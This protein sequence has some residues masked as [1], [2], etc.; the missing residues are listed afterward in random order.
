M[1]EHETQHLGG[2]RTRL[3]IFVQCLRQPQQVEN[4]LAAEAG[5]I[6]ESLHA[7]ICASASLKVSTWPSFKIYAGSRRRMRG[8]PLVPVRIF[9]DMSAAWT[10][11]AGREV[12]RPSKKPAPCTPVTGPMMQF[13]RM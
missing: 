2:E 12:L 5:Q 6:D 7:A 8:S 3:G 1:E 10:S 4:L 11:F 9:L 13:E